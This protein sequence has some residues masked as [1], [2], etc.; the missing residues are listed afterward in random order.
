MG[1]LAI[2][3]LHGSVVQGFFL[4]GVGQTEPLLHE[5]DAQ[6]GAH[7][8]RWAPGLTLRGRPDGDAALKQLLT[9]DCN[10]P[11]AGVG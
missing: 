5:V 4:S 6:Q 8:K 7:S 2:P 1:G 10:W 11:R 9:R 3:R